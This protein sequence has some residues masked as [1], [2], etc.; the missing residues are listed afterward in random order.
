MSI[1]AACITYHLIL[2]YEEYFYDIYLRRDGVSIPNDI[3][4]KWN[5]AMVKYTTTL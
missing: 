5:I 4:R 2:C 1:Y 3:F